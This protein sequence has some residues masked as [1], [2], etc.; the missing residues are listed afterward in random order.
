MYATR[1]PALA[2][3]SH[4]HSVRD[5]FPGQHFEAGRF[6]QQYRE[7]LRSLV[8]SDPEARQA[9]VGELIDI[10]LCKW[11]IRGAPCTKKN[12]PLRHEPNPHEGARIERL[13]ARRNATLQTE[14]DPNDPFEDKKS[15]K[16]RDDV[17]AKWIVQKFGVARLNSGEG[18]LD[19]AGGLGRLSFELLASHVRRMDVIICQ[20]HSLIDLVFREFELLLWSRE[21]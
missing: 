21:N 9:S 7:S 2:R 11:T 19:V 3:I 1:P 5:T 10:P 18:V 8:N 6:R 16:L 20:I 15:K 12:C 14:H 13:V 17:F 4:R